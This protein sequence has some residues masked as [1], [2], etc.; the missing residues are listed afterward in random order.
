M[1]RFID[2][3]PAPRYTES[4]A[5]DR[6][7]SGHFENFPPHPPNNQQ[8]QPIKNPFVTSEEYI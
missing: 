4:S 8:S 5:M 2:G 1:L 7:N 3:Y 6:Q